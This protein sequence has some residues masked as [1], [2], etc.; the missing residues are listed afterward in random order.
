[1][2]KVVT[3][4]VLSRVRAAFCQ[5][6]NGAMEVYVHSPPRIPSHIIAGARG[7]FGGGYA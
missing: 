5:T 4:S 2:D 3:L 7:L 6:E 1:M